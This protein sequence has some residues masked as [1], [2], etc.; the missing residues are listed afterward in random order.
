MHKEVFQGS[1]YVQESM[2]FEYQSKHG[3]ERGMRKELCGG[4]KC[5]Y[6]ELLS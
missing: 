2:L 1:A 3:T 5:M 6:I 4:C